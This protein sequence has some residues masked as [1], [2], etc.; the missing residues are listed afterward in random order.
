MS[1][2]EPEC[3]W[4]LPPGCFEGDP[5]APW[6]APDPLEGRKC[7]DCRYF[8]QLPIRHEGGVCLFEAMDEN[9]AAVS[10]ADGRGC[11]CEAFEP[12]A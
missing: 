11:A 5:N 2:F 3:G 6:N 7:G 10:L 1:G 9:V 4:N 12:C 8:G